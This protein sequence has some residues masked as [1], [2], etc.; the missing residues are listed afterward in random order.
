M[1]Y[2]AYG[3]FAFTEKAATTGHATSHASDRDGA[4]NSIG[5][6]GEAGK[7]LLTL[8]LLSLV[9][10]EDEDRDID[11]SEEINEGESGMIAGPG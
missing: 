9:K 2:L 10:G 7:K 11:V 4:C 6:G 3:L 5:G 8:S 1:Q